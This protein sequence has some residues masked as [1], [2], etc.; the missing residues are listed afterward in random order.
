[1]LY[2]RDITTTVLLLIPLLLAVPTIAL[3]F[4][5]IRGPPART[6]APHPSLFFI[7]FRNDVI[8][9][10]RPTSYDEIITLLHESTSVPRYKQLRVL[11]SL[12]GIREPVVLSPSVWDIL[13]P[14]VPNVTVLIEEADHRSSG[15]GIGG[16][17]IGGMDMSMSMSMGMG[18]GMGGG[19][20]N[21]D[22]LSPRDYALMMLPALPTHH[23]HRRLLAA[24]LA[25]S[26]SEGKGKVEEEEGEEEGVM[27]RATG[28]AVRGELLSALEKPA[29]MILWREEEE[30]KGKKMGATG[31]GAGAGI[32]LGMSMDVGMQSLDTTALSGALYDAIGA[33]QSRWASA[34]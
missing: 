29:E 18:M 26:L 30:A 12:P 27:R 5:I 6:P 7:H 33:E 23:H 4:L 2:V 25:L 24:P 16:M 28:A 11:A 13:G 19:M 22:A 10:R 8:A 31:V 20:G 3:F 14:R 34:N 17:G 32:G 1:M 15:S 21:G 9:T